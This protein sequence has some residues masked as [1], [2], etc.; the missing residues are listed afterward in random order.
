[1]VTLPIEIIPL[2]WYNM[3]VIKR[4]HPEERKEKK[5]MTRKQMAFRIISANADTIAFDIDCGDEVLVK[6]NKDE[7][8]DLLYKQ[9]LYGAS[10]QH[11]KF[12]TAEWIRQTII[13]E[14]EKACR[15]WGV[16][17]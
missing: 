2:K 12:L 7:L 17:L 14:L 11:F 8:V 5:K 4:E 15:R 16:E 13:K 1:M 3:Y 10:A 6:K 9:L